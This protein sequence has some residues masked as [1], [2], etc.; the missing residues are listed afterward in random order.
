MLENPKRVNF[1]Q[2]EREVDDDKV[3]R[4]SSDVSSHKESEAD[5]CAHHV[6]N[7]PHGAYHHEADTQ[8]GHSEN[9]TKNRTAASII[10]WHKLQLKPVL[11]VIIHPWSLS[12]PSK[13]LGVLDV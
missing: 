3:G 10:S 12:R 1:D 9:I 2:K 8:R 7:V 11:G 6:L 5:H 4:L 13:I